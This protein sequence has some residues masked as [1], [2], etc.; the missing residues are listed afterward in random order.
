V[1]F[2]SAGNLPQFASPALGL[3]LPRAVKLAKPRLLLPN[4]LAP[5]I[6]P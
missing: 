2:D 4:D 3:L 6:K 5:K 1:A